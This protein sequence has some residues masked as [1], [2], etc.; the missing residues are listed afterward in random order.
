MTLTEP[1][2]PPLPCHNPLVHPVPRSA[3][4]PWIQPSYSSPAWALSKNRFLFFM[5]PI[6]IEKPRD[7][8]TLLMHRHRYTTHNCKNLVHNREGK[9]DRGVH[10]NKQLSKSPH[11]AQGGEQEDSFNTPYK[12][13]FFLVTEHICKHSRRQALK[14]APGVACLG[15]GTQDHL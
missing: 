14:R 15:A 8:V 1:P 3:H 11:T 10:Q 7:T 6:E 5:P 9:M 4:A 13:V 2:P 12:R